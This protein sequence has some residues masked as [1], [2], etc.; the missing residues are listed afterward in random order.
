MSEET[1]EETLPEVVEILP[2]EQAMDQLIVPEKFEHLQRVASMF[3]KS[4]IVP[5]HYRGNVA[6]CSIALYMAY[7]LKCDPLLLMQHSYTVGGKMGFEAKFVIALA[8]TRGPFENGI[9]F[10]LTG[11]GDNIAAVAKGKLKSSGKYVSGPTI[12]MQQ[13]KALG[14]DVIKKKDGSRIPNPQWTHN[15]ELMLQYRAAT[16]LVRL[17]C[18]ELMMGLQTV[19]ELHDVAANTEEEK[20]G[21]SR[22]NGML[23][24]MN[25]GQ[26]E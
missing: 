26:S 11:K 4:S 25:G 14:W 5:D 8:N 22:I 19:E 24:E 20:R 12:T 7:G 18:P 6:N 3:S 2:P 21:E 23:A 15:R 13:V 10:K 9:E 16:Y 1:V 17:H